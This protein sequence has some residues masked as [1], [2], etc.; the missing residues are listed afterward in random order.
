MPV[1]LGEV[2]NL[3][4]NHREQ[5]LREEVESLR[6]ELERCRE[7]ETCWRQRLEQRESQLSLMKC[8][9]ETEQKTIASLEAELKDLQS[10]LEKDDT[11]FRN[12]VKNA[13]LM[14]LARCQFPC[15][16]R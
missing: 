6:H 3:I 9:L 12:E 5:R 8:E 14:I 4:R 13:R 1:F 16:T 11:S 10:K 15:N 2:F 7:S